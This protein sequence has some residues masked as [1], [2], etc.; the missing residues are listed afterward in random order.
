MADEEKQPEEALEA[1]NDDARE[2]IIA[3]TTGDGEKTYYLKNM[4]DISETKVE[5]K[6]EENNQLN[7]FHFT[8]TAV[9]DWKDILKL[10]GNM[11]LPKN[12][13]VIITVEAGA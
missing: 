4:V 2:Q 11:P 13:N 3:V 9:T 6:Q 8:F 5:L 10:V 7:G 12:A 1:K